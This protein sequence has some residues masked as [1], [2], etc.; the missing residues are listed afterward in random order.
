MSLIRKYIKTAAIA[1]TAVFIGISSPSAAYLG[2][3][4]ASWYA[5]TSRTASGEMMNA[6]RLTAAHRTLAFGTLVRVTHLK[7]KSSVIVCINDRGPFTGNRV[8]DLSK[9]A[10]SQIGLIHDG[11]AKVKLEKIGKVAACTP[12]KKKQLRRT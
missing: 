7:K 3:G 4:K 11:V 5:L 2:T 9:A 12:K 6:A 8:I 10:A 1:A